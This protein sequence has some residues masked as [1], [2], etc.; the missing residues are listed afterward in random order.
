MAERCGYEWTT[1][2]APYG[3]REHSCVRPSSHDAGPP[4]RHRCGCGAVA[5]V[6]GL[7]RGPADG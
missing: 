3:W 6:A 5:T 1:P 7:M 4:A 2:K